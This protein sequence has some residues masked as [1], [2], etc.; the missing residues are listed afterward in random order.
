MFES[1]HAFIFLGRFTSSRQGKDFSGNV[2]YEQEMVCVIAKVTG[3]CQ[4]NRKTIPCSLVL[5]RILGLIWQYK[6]TDKPDIFW[7]YLAPFQC[8]ISDYYCVL[9]RSQWI[10]I[11]INKRWK[12]QSIIAILWEHLH[13]FSQCYR[14][15]SF[16]LWISSIPLKLFSASATR[17]TF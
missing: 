4:S 2:T 11:N 3:S 1:R 9:G 10:N 15:Y 5:C 13:K 17:D 8:I 12:I 6:F 7:L 14:F 16:S